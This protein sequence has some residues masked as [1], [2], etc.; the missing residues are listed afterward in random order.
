MKEKGEDKYGMMMCLVKD[1]K[2]ELIKEKLKKRFEAA[3]GKK[4]D[5]MA[6]LIVKLVIEKHKSKMEMYRKKEELWNH[7]K[8]VYEA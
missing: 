6:D 5:E 7:L 8:S 2:E 1:A 3:E 4:L